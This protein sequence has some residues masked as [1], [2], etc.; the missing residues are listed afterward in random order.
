MN[1]NNNNSDDDI[2]ISIVSTS[3]RESAT[4][5]GQSIPPGRFLLTGSNIQFSFVETGKGKRK[6]KTST[7][8]ASEAQSSKK[9]NSKSSY[10]RS[11]AK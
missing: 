5:K 10:G 6:S 7:K 2:Y 3:T 8:K 9:S 4:L 11:N 1:S